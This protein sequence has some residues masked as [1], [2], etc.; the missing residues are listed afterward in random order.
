MK[1]TSDI[2]IDFAD[3]DQIL[4]HI[5]HTPASIRRDNEA[6]R[7]NTGV[8]VTKIPVDPVQNTA[9]LDYVAAEE[10]GYVKLDLLNVWLYK[11]VRDEQHLI[12]LMREP[13][14][15]RL[16]DRE[17]FEQLIHLRNHYE[18]QRSMPEPIDSIPRLAMFLSVI[19][20]GKRHLIGKPWAEVAKT[21]WDKPDDGSYYFKK[22][23]AIAYAHLVVVH[24]NLLEDNPATCVLPE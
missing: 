16:K 1:F 6:R 14:W 9:A 12:Q 3:R 22:S 5:R 23:H 10:R 8:Y 2:D 21:I 7:H 4:Q 19:R 15:Y 20:P 17:F 13:L 11:H 24:M 18:T